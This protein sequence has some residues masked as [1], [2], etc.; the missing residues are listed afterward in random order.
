MSDPLTV[1][2]GG[3]LNRWMSGCV[4]AF[5]RH[6]GAI[7]AINVFPVADS[8]T[9]TNLLLTLRSA[10][11]ATLRLTSHP[12]A[13]EA[14]AAIAS[15]A[16]AGARGNSGVIVSQWLRGLAEAATGRRLIDVAVLQAGLR[17]AL[18]LARTA[19]S[20]PEPGTV[21]TVLQRVHEAVRHRADSAAAPPT[22][23][24]L[25]ALAVDTAR[26]ALRETTG[27][28]AALR[29]AGVVD[30]GAAGLVI[31]LQELDAVIAGASPGGSR[32][33][34]GLDA[35]AVAVTPPYRAGAELLAVREGGSVEYGYEVMY[36]LEE[37]A[38][39]AAGPAAEKLSAT[40]RVLGDCVSV[41]SDGGALWTVHV[42]CDD[43]GAAIEAGLQYGNP[44]R[45]T[46]SRFADQAHRRPARFD[47][48]RAVVTL[49]RGA[50]IARLF[51]SAGAAVLA[52]PEGTTPR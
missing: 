33:P 10:M 37:N 27:A 8:D 52:L 1:L 51:R 19:V 12:T 5:E 3:S 43:I 45:I 4:R 38:R 35:G 31:V 41:V 32:L 44:S 21:L 20:N 14:I 23:A 50:G 24:E 36:L 34:E 47:S 7:D 26:T 39:T 18:E 25:S 17:R 22:L 30:A 11:D 13:S 9:G 15:G 46:V 42:H 6:R 28:L 2:E 29:A 40:L 49:A 16:L 48:E